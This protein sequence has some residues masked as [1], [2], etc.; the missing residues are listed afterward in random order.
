M[1]S[2]L[3]MGNKKSIFQ[4][5]SPVFS[6]LP[7]HNSQCSA[8]CLVWGCLPA[9]SSTCLISGI[10]LGQ[11]P[12]RAGW[13]LC[14][15]VALQ[16]WHPRCT[17][18]SPGEVAWRAAGLCSI[19]PC[20]HPGCWCPC[21]PQSSQAWGLYLPGVKVV[22]FGQ[23]SLS[24]PSLES[25]PL[26]GGGLLGL[27]PGRTRAG[28]EEDSPRGKAALLQQDHQGCICRVGC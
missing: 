17:V 4:F 13:C 19:L 18:V 1:L 7:P 5:I 8:S 11:R 10:S 15:A 16:P 2:G 24:F 25:R 9:F 28:P 21:P 26:P 20:G 14:S 23:P 27:C 3:N 12:L 22:C 6:S